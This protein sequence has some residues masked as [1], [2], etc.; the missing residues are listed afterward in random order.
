VSDSERTYHSPLREAQAEQTRVHIVETMISQLAETGGV[1][2]SIRQLADAA[3]VSERTV[4]RYF[5]D[6]DALLDAV[7]DHFSEVMSTGRREE[8]LADLDELARFVPDVFRDFDRHAAAT[9][10]SILI[11]PDPARLLPT[12]QRR[13]E[14]IIDVCRRTFPDLPAADQRRLGQLIRTI[15]STFNWLRMREEFAMTADES[16]ELIGWVVQCVTDEIRRTGRLGAPRE[17]D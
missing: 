2:F 11:N 15:T 5:P 17:P 16:G 10:A 4:Y 12:Q 8:E 14:L 9:K 6:R 7:N 3:R 1:D 13:T